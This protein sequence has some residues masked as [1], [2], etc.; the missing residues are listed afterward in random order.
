[1]W[2]Q[3][4]FP[5]VT[6]VRSPI[7]HS[8]GHSLC[9]GACPAGRFE[10]LETPCPK[11]AVVRHSSDLRAGF[12][13]WIFVLF[14][15]KLWKASPGTQELPRNHLL[16]DSGGTAG[17]TDTFPLLGLTFNGHP[18]LPGA[19]LSVNSA[20]HRN[21]TGLC[22]TDLKSRH[23]VPSMHFCIHMGGWERKE[24]GKIF[25]KRKGR[26]LTPFLQEQGPREAR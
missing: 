9:T 2:Q 3:H 6:R 11:F 26:F 13:R 23:Y 20:F 8:L 1:M 17:S 19:K 25:L 16:P 5:E 22:I 15:R 7:Q 10:L 18:H 12:G 4:R 14:P 21:L 24:K